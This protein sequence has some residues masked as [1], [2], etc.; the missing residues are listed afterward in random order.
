MANVTKS[1]RKRIQ[2]VCVIPFRGSDNQREFC[3]VTS[4]KK[5][6][7]IFPKGIVDPGE[8]PEQ[9]GLKE[10]WEEAGLRGEICGE[11]VGRFADSKWG[12]DLDVLVYVMRVVVCETVWPEAEQ[13]KRRWVSLDDAMQR[14][15][16]AEVRILLGRAQTLLSA[17]Q[18]PGSESG[19][20][21]GSPSS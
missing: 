7:W 21:G 12:A 3:L 20:G 5:K 18:F 9:T 17:D 16:R 13:R 6:R 10:A 1:P 11:P 14:L 15:R 8:T 4:L 19:G 2:Q